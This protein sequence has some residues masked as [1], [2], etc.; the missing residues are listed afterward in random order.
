MINHPTTILLIE[1]DADVVAQIRTAVEALDVLVSEVVNS[2]DEAIQLYDMLVPDVVVLSA[3]FADSP[4]FD[5]LRSRLQQAGQIPLIYRLDSAEAAAPDGALLALTPPFTP[6]AVRRIVGLALRQRSEAMLQQRNRELALL[7]DATRKFTASLDV[8]ELLVDLMGEVRQMFEAD[9]MSVWLLDRQTEEL[10]CRISHGPSADLVEGWRLEPKAGIA[11]WVAHHGQS[12]VVQDTRQMEQHIKAV[13]RETGVEMRSILCVPMWRQQQVNGVIQILDSR[14]G[15]FSYEDLAMVEALASAAAVAIE[16]ASL[17][18]ETEHLLEMTQEALSEMETL[19]RVANMFQSVDDLPQLLDT[20]AEIIDD[21]L[22]ADRVAVITCDMAAREITHIA[23]AGPSAERLVDIDFDEVWEGLSGWVLRERRPTI[24]PKGQLDP[25]ESPAVQ[26]RRAET[27]CG[28][29]MLVPIQT[30]STIWGTITAINRPHQPDFTARELDL[31]EIIANHAANVIQSVQLL[32]SLRQSEERFRSLI[33]SMD[34]IVFTLDREQRHTGVYGRW[35]EKYGLDPEVFLGK[36]SREALGEAAQVHETAN[37]RALAGEHVVYEWSMQ[38]GPTLVHIQTS[39]SP[40][41][42]AAGEIIGIVGVG[43]DITQLRKME[44]MQARMAA[45]VASSDDAII[46]KT[47]DGIITSWNA[48]A[49]RV[50]GYSPKEAIGQSI[51]DLIAPHRPDEIAQIMA[52]IRRGEPIDHFE[53]TRIRK[54]GNKIDVSLTVSPVRDQADDL[55]GASAI[56]RDITAEKRAEQQLRESQK[57]LS[58]VF[59]SMLD[60]IF[61]LNLQAEIIDCNPAASEMFGYPCQ[62]LMGKTTA[63]LHVDEASLATFRAHLYPAIEEH[64][65]LLLSDFQMRRRDGTI[66]PTEHSVAPLMEDGERTGWVSV[67]RDITTRKQAEEDLQQRTEELAMLLAVGQTIASELEPERLHEVIV[68]QMMAAAHAPN[69]MLYRLDA[70][71]ETLR[72]MLE[73]CVLEEM[74]SHLGGASRA[75]NDWP[76]LRAVIEQCQPIILHRDAPDVDAAGRAYLK[77][78][79]A[80]SL[81][82]VPLCVGKQSLG[83]M[84]LREP[85]EVRD[86]TAAEIRLCQGVAD[87]AAVAWHQ[88]QLYEV[89]R[90]QGEQ[91]RTLTA[92]LIEADESE[93]Q[94]LAQALH[95]QMGQELSALG[96]QLQI[97]QMLLKQEKSEAAQE[98]VEEAV[99]VTKRVSKQVRELMEDLRAPVLED[100]GLL[101]ALQWYASLFSARH[102]ISIKVQGEEPQPGLILS[103]ENALFRI[104]QEALNS[105]VAQSSLSEV[106]IRLTSEPQWVRI[107]LWGDTEHVD[108]NLMEAA[109]YHPGD[110]LVSIQERAEVIGGACRVEAAPEGGTLVIVE[111]QR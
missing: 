86:F 44:E 76:M 77:A 98:R 110:R 96:I 67:V 10:V 103:A 18:E 2:P 26:K 83:I 108:L 68:D 107:T 95:D 66:F 60:A 57:L 15:R 30:S 104:V 109:I 101:T 78:A 73:R 47:L 29:I 85:D 88:A 43:R 4:D 49:T 39:L 19:Y 24:S 42:N 102:E 17:Y 87:Q 53:T 65:Y 32:I 14:P 45:I 62:E 52:K 3:R 50:Y 84:Q 13:D 79:K 70:E 25:R 75:L 33:E 36:T 105:L 46:S 6:E 80:A 9:A 81:L 55:I 64:G 34:D 21:V 41:Y 89:V 8:D 90:Q 69:G 20:L 5:A 16:N 61:I 106:R 12:L 28:S 92:R 74:C 94:W 11:G 22:T 97:T 71:A 91:L 59:D 40:M 93:R 56:A 37:R 111:V 38:H 1:D 27:E 23:K 72:P 82:L 58:K 51:V 35:M 48:G 54:D 31:V 100:Y 7:H 99:A 63:L